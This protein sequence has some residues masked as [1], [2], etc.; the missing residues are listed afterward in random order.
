MQLI[1]CSHA[2]HSERKSEFERDVRD[3]L[4]HSRT[5]NR[6]HDIT[7][8]LLT[9][10]DMFFHV[11]EGMPVALGT[12]Y[13]KIM[14]DDRHDGIVVLQYTVVHVRLFDPWPLAFLRVG[15]VLHAKELH[16]YSAPLELRTVAIAILKASR[17]M[18]FE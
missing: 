2:T 5:Y 14:H 3:I 8:A 1:Y 15:P 6:L 12:L 9:D 4:E 17:P 16:A 11:V 7:G 10:G 18:F 13:S